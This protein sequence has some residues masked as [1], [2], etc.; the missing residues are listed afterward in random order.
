MSDPM[1]P[2]THLGWS[3]RYGT[4]AGYNQFG[5]AIWL[6]RWLSMVAISV[7]FFWESSLVLEGMMAVHL[8]Q[9]ALNLIC[10]QLHI[11]V[12]CVNCTATAP[13][14]ATADLT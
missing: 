5:L 13:L 8:Y 14:T 2:H 11:Q 7:L 10:W 12:P 6:L 4:P 9:I 3:G 1:G